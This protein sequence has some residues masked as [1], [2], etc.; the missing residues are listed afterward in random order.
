MDGPAFED[1][2]HAEHD[3]QAHGE[4]DSQT[5]AQRIAQ[6]RIVVVGYDAA[7]GH[8]GGRFVGHGDEGRLG[9]RGAES[10]CES[11]DEQP[12]EAT[13]AGECPR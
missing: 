10:E 9:D 13:L 1:T 12:R 5:Q 2:E 4:R 6:S 11:E 8:H 7:F 3:S